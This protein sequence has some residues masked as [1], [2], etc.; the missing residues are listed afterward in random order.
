MNIEVG[1]RVETLVD[2]QYTENDPYTI[3]G[4]NYFSDKYPAGTVCIVLHI[5]NNP[6][7][8]TVRKES[9]IKQEMRYDLMFAPLY[10][11][12]DLKLL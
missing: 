3:M 10:D 2:T 1:S 9:V 8:I 6:K 11:E 12:E 4:C 5:S 7:M